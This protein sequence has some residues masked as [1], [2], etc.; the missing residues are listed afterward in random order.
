MGRESSA[1]TLISPGFVIEIMTRLATLSCAL[2]APTHNN[3]VTRAK[4]LIK[5]SPAK[6]QRRKENLTLRLC[7]FAG[8]FVT[9]KK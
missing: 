2:T 9:G 8:N 4:V 1:S 3:T 5:Q 7:A 6:A